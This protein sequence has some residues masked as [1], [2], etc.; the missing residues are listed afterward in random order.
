MIFSFVHNHNIGG[1]GKIPGIPI[2]PNI[3]IG[4]LKGGNLVCAGD[5]VLNPVPPKLVK[6][7]GG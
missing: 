2:P 5:N 4:G 7:M 6:S 3:P 1:P